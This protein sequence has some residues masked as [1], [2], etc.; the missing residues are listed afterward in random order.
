MRNLKVYQCYEGDKLL[1]EGT[2]EEIGEFLDVDT[3]LVRSK[4]S[5]DGLKVLGKYSIRKTDKRKNVFTG[6]IRIEKKPKPRSAEVIED[7]IFNL[8][9]NGNSY[10]GREDPS[11]LFPVLEELGLTCRCYTETEYPERKG[12]R[13]RMPE[14]ITHY[15][16]EVI[17]ARRKR[18][19]I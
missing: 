7:I 12:D 9:Y 8:L 16:L 15:Y 2:A 11:S 1:L 19:S 13:G 14:P 6:R 3:N 18:E 5:Q 10:V 4:S 17:N